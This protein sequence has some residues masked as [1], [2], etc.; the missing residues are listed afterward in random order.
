MPRLIGLAVAALLVALVHW[1]TPDTFGAVERAAGD[2]TW[3]VGASSDRA[4][5]R[6]VIVD[7]DEH[8]LSQVGPWPWPRATIADLSR[9]LAQ[10]GAGSQIYDIVFPD[11]REGDAELVAA[12]RASSVTAGQIFSIDSTVRPRVGELGGALA[13]PGC[14]GIA[15]QSFGYIANAAA[16]GGSGVSIGHLTPRVEHDGVIRKVPALVC[17][18]GRA[19]PALALAALWR[20]SQANGGDPTPMAPDWRAESPATSG[21][22]GGFFAPTAVLTSAALPG[23]VVPVDAQGDMRVP[24]RLGRNGLASVSASEVLAGRADP[25]LLKGAVVLIGATAFGL[26]DT[27]ATPQAAV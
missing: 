22:S 3:R 19:Y 21:L 4:E 6:V 23:L 26:G 10:A 14:P 17:H 2:L 8:S 11:P 24:Y 16:M 1:L 18:Q 27:K 7:I 20:L 15:P 5:R 9:K 13:M 25:A 12:W